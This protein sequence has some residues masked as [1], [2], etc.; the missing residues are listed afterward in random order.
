MSAE[1]KFPIRVYIEDTDCYGM[2]YH[3]KYLNYLERTRTE[4]LTSLGFDL[5][6][7]AN[8][9]LYFAIQKINIEFFKP[10]FLNEYI[11]V[12]ASLNHKTRIILDFKQT[13]L[14]NTKTEPEL[15]CQAD[16]KLV[17]INQQL[18]PIPIPSAL[19]EKL[20]ES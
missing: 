10:L 13:I 9:G 5:V 12:T 11:D 7:C 1:F 16:L 6:T 15:V 2:V 17:C 4:W 8:M 20:N 3:S 19:E 14:R 18:K